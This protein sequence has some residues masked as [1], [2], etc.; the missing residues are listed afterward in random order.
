MD[1][2]TS[3][4]E[5]I[6]TLQIVDILIA[7]AIILLFRILSST[8]SYIIIRMFKYKEKKYDVDIID[9]ELHTQYANYIQNALLAVQTNAE[10]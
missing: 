10:Q 8:F 2:F 3:F 1:Q 4:I 7:V 9:T 6:K 5:N